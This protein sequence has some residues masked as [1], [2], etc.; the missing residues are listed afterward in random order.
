MYRVCCKLAVK[1]IARLRG[2]ENEILEIHAHTKSAN[3]NNRWE[4]VV[5][6]KISQV[7]NLR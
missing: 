2:R 5:R 1:Q 6:V 7:E 4:V 3:L